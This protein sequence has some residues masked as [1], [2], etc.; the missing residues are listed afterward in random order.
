MPKTSSAT[1]PGKGEHYL[2]YAYPTSIV[3]SRLNR[4]RTGCFYV[5]RADGATAA[6][7]FAEAL[8]VAAQQPTVPHRWS[9]D[10]PFNLRYLCDEDQARVA[11]ARAAVEAHNDLQ[12]A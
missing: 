3:A 1:T 2:S 5:Q 11:A 8:Q 6:G 7:S 9:M 10:H 12:P 4:A